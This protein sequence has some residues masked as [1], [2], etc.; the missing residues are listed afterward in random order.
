[1]AI[2]CRSRKWSTLRCAVHCSRQDP[3]AHARRR[4]ISNVDAP[5][6]LTPEPYR[7]RRHPASP[8]ASFRTREPPPREQTIRS[9]SFRSG[10]W[11]PRR[12]QA[13]LTLRITTTRPDSLRQAESRGLPIHILKSNSVSQVRDA[14][15][16]IYGVDRH[17]KGRPCPGRGRAAIKT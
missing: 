1:V 14:L 16:R 13:V 15:S 3:H 2:H 7:R 10:C 9:W 6:V 11:E 8:L 5:I 17:D 12:A 4:L